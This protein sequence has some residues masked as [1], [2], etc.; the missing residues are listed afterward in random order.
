[1]EAARSHLRRSEELGAGA[2]LPAWPYRLRLVQAQLAALEGA[3]DRALDLLDTAER[4]SYRGPLPELQPVAARRA[5]VWIR[6]GRL[7]SIRHWAREGG[8][9]VDDELTYTRKFEHITLARLLLAQAWHGE[10]SLRAAAHLLG[11]LLTAAEAGGRVGSTIEILVLQALAAQAGG[12][13]PAALRGL[14]RAL[15]LAEPEGYVRVFVDEG[16]PLADADLPWPIMCGWSSDRDEGR[17]EEIAARTVNKQRRAARR[18][19]RR[20]ATGRAAPEARR[21]RAASSPQ[22]R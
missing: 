13:R 10:G 3:L 22:L 7:A 9:A 12:D 17:A 4:H 14:G 6:Q 20:L 16:A 2:G 15:A 8:L 19:L 21:G 18:L 5:R 1:M 11:R